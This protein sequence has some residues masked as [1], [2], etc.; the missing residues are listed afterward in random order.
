MKTPTPSLRTARAPQRDLPCAVIRPLSRRVGCRRHGTGLLWN[1]PG[2]QAVGPAATAGRWTAAC[3]RRGDVSSQL[4]TGPE[5]CCWGPACTQKAPASHWSFLPY[6]QGL[7][8]LA[9]GRARNGRGHCAWE[10]P[11]PS[12]MR[13]GGQRS[14]VKPYEGEPPSPPEAPDGARLPTLVTLKWFLL[15]PAVCLTPPPTP[16]PLRPPPKQSHRAH[17]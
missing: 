14:Q 9:E 5:H 7:G 16:C 3:W 11:S 2:R 4:G 6:G 10:W 17:T 8:R 12:D 1:L 15:F 13:A